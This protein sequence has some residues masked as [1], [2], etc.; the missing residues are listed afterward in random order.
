MKTFERKAQKHFSILV[1]IFNAIVQLLIGWHMPHDKEVSIYVGVAI[2]IGY[3]IGIMILDP[4]FK[5][6]LSINENQLVIKENDNDIR[7]LYG[8]IKVISIKRKYLLIEDSF[9]A[10]VSLAYNQELKDFLSPYIPRS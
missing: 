6:Q 10:K 9:G 8:K 5:Y 7:I 2:F 1:I 4:D 3:V